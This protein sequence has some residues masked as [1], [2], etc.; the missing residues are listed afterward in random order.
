VVNDT[1]VMRYTS[2]DG[3]EGFP[4]E[5]KVTVAFR[6]TGD[7]T[8]ELNYK[9]TTSQPTVVN[10]TSHP[11]LNLGGHVSMEGLHDFTDVLSE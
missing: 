10:L 7:N 4:G 5:V 9:A 1:V 11:Y 8:L 2:P 3:E 6:L